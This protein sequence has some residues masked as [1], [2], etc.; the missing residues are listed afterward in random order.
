MTL[1]FED[2]LKLHLGLMQALG[3]LNSYNRNIVAGRDS[4]I[5][6]CVFTE[7][8]RITINESKV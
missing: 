1:S 3:K 6:L 8:S 5:N 4:A 2:A 7:D